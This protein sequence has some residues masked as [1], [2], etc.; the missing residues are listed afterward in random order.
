MTVTIPECVVLGSGQSILDL[1]DQERERLNRAECRLA[2][3]KYAAFSELAGITPTHVFF[4]DDYD[5]TCRRFLQHIFNR[6]IESSDSNLTFVIP[7][8]SRNRL[9]TC[10]AEELQR[11]Q[12]RLEW[13]GFRQPPFALYRPVTPRFPGKY[14][15]P[16]DAQ[17]EFTT[18]HEWRTGGE[19]ATSLNQPLFHFRGS[20][21]SALNYLSIQFPGWPVR[22]VGTDFAGGEYFFQSELD[23][24]GF[25]WRDWTTPLV[26]EANLHFSAQQF[27]GTT[28]FDRFEFIVEQMERTG[29]PLVCQ[30][31]NSALVK[32]Q[33]VAWEPVPTSGEPVA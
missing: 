32:R 12:G 3:N 6:C 15:V 19:W 2:L 16:K 23:Q 25:E 9:R 17:F 33:L 28:M 24:L 14:L 10:S 26:A 21:T 30:S 20:L 13:L 8:R 11:R 18:H 29:T 5:M 22:L 31:R 1:S 4:L 27:E 7:R